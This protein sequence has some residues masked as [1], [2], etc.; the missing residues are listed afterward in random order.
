MPPEKHAAT[1]WA[2]RLKRVFDIDVQTCEACG[3]GVKIIAAARYSMAIP[4]GAESAVAAPPQAVTMRACGHC[5]P[6]RQGSQQTGI[7]PANGL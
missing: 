4:G 7:V 3:G 5:H 2:Q 1:T 6:D